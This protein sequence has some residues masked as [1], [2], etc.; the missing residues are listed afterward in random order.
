M[1]SIQNLNDV[2]IE[3]AKFC[4]SLWYAFFDI[5]GKEDKK[6]NEDGDEGYDWSSLFLG[7]TDSW[8]MLKQQ[9]VKLNKNV[10]ILREFSTRGINPEQYI[11]GCFQAICHQDIEYADI[12]PKSLQ[13]QGVDF[14]KALPDI[15]KKTIESRLLSENVCDYRHNDVSCCL[16]NEYYKFPLKNKN[17]RDAERYACS[18]LNSFH[19]FF[20]L[21]VDDVRARYHI[22]AVAL[23]IKVFLQN[24]FINMI[25][26]E[27][28][29]EEGLSVEKLT[30][31]IIDQ[32]M[33]EG[34]I[35]KKCYLTIFHFLVMNLKCKSYVAFYTQI[36]L[37][38][39]LIKRG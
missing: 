26:E 12:L 28:L 18:L 25:M 34:K 22:D 35:S 11:T 13:L 3:K 9:G 27:N 37:C 16:F 39:Y 19:I 33:Q 20:K 15:I 2:E 23:F 1:D 24:N 8:K 7:L 14:K 30:F 17:D 29:K 32:K 10:Y 31:R 4:E 36:Q 6:K 5:I 21:F 38:I